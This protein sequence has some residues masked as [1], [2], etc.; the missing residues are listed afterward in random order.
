MFNFFLMYCITRPVGFLK[1]I[2]RLLALYSIN[3]YRP[4]NFSNLNFILFFSLYY[5]SEN[6]LWCIHFCA[7]LHII[8]ALKKKQKLS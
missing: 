7:F 3:Y 2:F 4:S 8:Y 1:Y 5:I 6:F